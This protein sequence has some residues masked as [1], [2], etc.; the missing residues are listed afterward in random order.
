MKKGQKIALGVGAVLLLALVGFF[1]WKKRWQEFTNIGDS[2]WLPTTKNNGRL[3]IRPASSMHGIKPG[4]SIEIEHASS[5][6]PQGKTTVL[7]VVSKN[8]IEYI[9]T[10]LAATANPDITGKFR[11]VA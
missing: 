2:T 8:G 4:N 1:F 3:A 6:V 10:S 9:V 11:F 7:D 5:R